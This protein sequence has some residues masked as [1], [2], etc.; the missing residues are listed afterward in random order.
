MLIRLVGGDG[1]QTDFEQVAKY[2]DVSCERVNDWNDRLGVT[3]DGEQ[4]PAA[5]ISGGLLSLD[6][7]GADNGQLIVNGCC[8]S[9]LARFELIRLKSD[10]F[11]FLSE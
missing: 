3:I 2:G 8:I 4:I 6:K 11:R 10:V 9:T 1:L 7:M 5:I